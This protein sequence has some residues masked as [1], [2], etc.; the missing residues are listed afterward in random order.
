V[1]TLSTLSFSQSP[2]SDTVVQFFLL[3]SVRN[4]LAKS[5]SLSESDFI[6][7]MLHKD[8]YYSYFYFI[9]TFTIATTLHDLNCG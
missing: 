2:T 9:T 1:L 4:L 7:R 5:A 6:I 8:C 3:K